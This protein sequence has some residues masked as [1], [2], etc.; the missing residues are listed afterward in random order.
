M[1]NFILFVSLPTWQHHRFNKS[2]LKST[3]N[4]LVSVRLE[5]LDLLLLSIAHRSSAP[6]KNMNFTVRALPDVALKDFPPVLKFRFSTRLPPTTICS[7]PSVKWPPS[8]SKYPRGWM[9]CVCVCVS[10]GVGARV[11][12]LYAV[13][14]VFAWRNGQLPPID[15]TYRAS[16]SLPGNSLTSTSALL[17]LTRL[18]RYSSWSVQTNIYK[19]SWK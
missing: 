19:S 6:T 18:L 3:R 15:L 12:T 2:D 10:L 5:S 8:C 14:S 1:F 7:H 17:P 13:T 9:E 16:N 11:G 4:P